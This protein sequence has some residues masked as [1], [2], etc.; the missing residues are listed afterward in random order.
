MATAHPNNLSHL[1]DYEHIKLYKSIPSAMV[2]DRADNVPSVPYTQRAALRHI[3][4]AAVVANTPANTL[5]MILVNF[6]L[7]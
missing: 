5:I 2:Y 3:A 4:I 6:L 7:I 1:F